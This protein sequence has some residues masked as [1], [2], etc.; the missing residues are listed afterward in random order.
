MDSMCIFIIVLMLF[1]ATMFNFFGQKFVGCPK[2]TFG[3]VFVELVKVL[4]TFGMLLIAFNMC[5]PKICAEPFHFELTPEKHCL[6]GD[7]MRTSNPELQK[8]CSQ[9]S[10][11][12]MANYNCPSGFIGMPRIFIDNT[13]GNQPLSNSEFENTTCNNLGDGSQDPHVI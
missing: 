12:D 3:V 7:Y 11:A 6:N 10:K 13:T 5:K 1:L 2:N 8:F 9:F 4:L